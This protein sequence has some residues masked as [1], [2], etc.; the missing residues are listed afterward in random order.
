MWEVKLKELAKALKPYGISRKQINDT[1][2]D[3]TGSL[4]EY[5]EE[6]QKIWYEWNI[7]SKISYADVDPSTMHVYGATDVILVLELAKMLI[8]IVKDK[9]QMEVLK[10]E[11]QLVMPLV[12]MERTGYP[13]DKKYL[14]RCKQALVFEI[15]TI[16]NIINLINVSAIYLH[17]VNKI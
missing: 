12:R 8:P 16:K 13:V 17:I 14:I 15:N 6:V 10:R 3:V 2:K 1:L 9:N 4:D 5:T 7:S 11:M